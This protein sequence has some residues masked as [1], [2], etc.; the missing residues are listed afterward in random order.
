MKIRLAFLVLLTIV[1]EACVARYTSKLGYRARQAVLQEDVAAFD[2]LMAEAAQ[3]PPSSPMDNPTRT[4]LSHFLDLGA[5]DRYFAMIESWFAKGW[6]S[7][8]MT[9]AIQ[10]GR[11]RGVRGKDPAEA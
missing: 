9:C 5:G 10:Q 2:G 4:V 3:T 1:T 7:D 11:Y 6:V 8:N